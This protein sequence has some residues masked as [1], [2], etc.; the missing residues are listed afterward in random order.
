MEEFRLDEYLN[1]EFGI[2]DIF[3][4]CFRPRRFKPYQ[5]I[6]GVERTIEVGDKLYRGIG[7]LYCDSM[8]EKQ[9]RQDLAKLIIDWKFYNEALTHASEL[10]WLAESAIIREETK[11]LD[12][13]SVEACKITKINLTL[14][15]SILNKLEYRTE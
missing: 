8:T 13:D 3:K 2:V 4:I 9:F 10:P 6:V 5:Q 12:F 14:Y 11:I 15:Q 7:F 1:Y